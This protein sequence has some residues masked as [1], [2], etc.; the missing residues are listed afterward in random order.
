M[1]TKGLL[2]A[3]DLRKSYQGHPV[4]RGVSLQVESGKV[5]GL[6]GPNGAGKTTCFSMIVGI[7]HPERG[8]LLME[9]RDITNLAIHE[10]VRLGMGYLPQ[11]PSV[12]RRLSVR[13]NLLAAVEVLPEMDSDTRTKRIDE[14]LAAFKLEALA[15]SEAAMLSGG[16][17]RRLEV[18]R[19]V[20]LNPRFVLL[21]EP[22]AGV[23][24]VAVDG[25]KALIKTLRDQD[26]GVLITDHN[27]REALDLCDHVYLLHDGT[28]CV[29]GTS[30]YIVKNKQARAIYLGDSFNP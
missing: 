29:E 16:E 17:R 12:F 5:V 15:D 14:L 13:E 6:L 10:R 28:V 21:D 27:V 25:I 4:V 24:P 22:F 20:A 1:K 9:G 18:A 7:E 3:K 8:S 11:E 2:A 19:T 23:D 26:I 30:E